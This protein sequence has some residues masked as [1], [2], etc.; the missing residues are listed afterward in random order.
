MREG[1]HNCKGIQWR[2]PLNV[3]HH[4]TAK[5]IPIAGCSVCTSQFYDQR[6]TPAPL[7]KKEKVLEEVNSQLE[8]ILNT[9]KAVKKASL[10]RANSAKFFANGGK[11]VL[12]K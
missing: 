4:P 11:E 5:G 8:L 1:K 6:Y 10:Q 3:Q 2:C 9:K 12:T 7:T